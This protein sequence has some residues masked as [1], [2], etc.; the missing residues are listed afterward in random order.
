M[1]A[2]AQ[3]SGQAALGLSCRLASAGEANSFRV[4]VPPCPFPR[5]TEA[6]ELPGFSARSTEATSQ[7]L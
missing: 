6:E 4:L 3:N 7:P 5:G 2:R 1:W